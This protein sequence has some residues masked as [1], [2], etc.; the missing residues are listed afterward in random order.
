MPPIGLFGL[1]FTFCLL[2]YALIAAW[3]VWP[4]LHGLPREVALVPLLW[5][6]VFRVAGATI[7]APGAID[8]GI[9]LDFQTTV[10]LGDFATAV[11]ALVAIV[12]LRQRAPGAIALVWLCL[13]VGTADTVN[14]IIQ[15]VRYDVFTFA[16][17]LNWAIVTL[18]VPALVVSSTLILV[19]LVGP[20]RAPADAHVQEGDDRLGRAR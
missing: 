8:P 6:H 15:S 10:G 16:L 14:A 11:L 13:L 19:T 12:A 17:G 2:A 5:V 4:R 1:Q 7:L 9:P 20:G 3:Y 18:Y